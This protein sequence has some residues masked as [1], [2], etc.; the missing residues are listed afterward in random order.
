MIDK[1]NTTSF[2]HESVLLTEAIASLAI[3]PA[4][5]YID[6]TFGRGGHSRAIL[7][8]L[9]ANG[10]LLVIDKD[11]TAVDYAQSCFKEEERVSIQHG[12]FRYL[13]EWAKTAWPEQD[14]IDGILFDLG[15]SS[16]QIDDPH[17]GFSFSQN[18]PLDMRMDTSNGETAADW[19]ATAEPGDIAAV[20]TRYGEERYAKRIAEAIVTARE[21][22]PITHTVQLAELIAKA[23]PARDRHKHPATRTFQA[24]RIYINSELADLENALSQAVTLLKKGGRLVVIS[25]HSL[26]DRITK[27]FIQGHAR[28]PSVPRGL[29]VKTLKSDHIDLQICGKAIKPSEAEVARNPRAR[30][31]MLRVAEKLV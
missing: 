12:S 3:K 5:Y 27:H 20:L 6:A 24:I 1:T 4:G 14:K 17:R 9:N 8:H 30:S 13:Q 28:A 19:L 23:S 26:E 22:N 21:R 7:S 18:G 10:R 15:I 16:P 25:F 11:R 31:A 2:N 29:P